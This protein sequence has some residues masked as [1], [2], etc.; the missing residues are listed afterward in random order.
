M[1]SSDI[2]GCGAMPRIIHRFNRE[3][4]DV[5]RERTP[6][7]FDGNDLVWI[8]VYKRCEYVHLPQGS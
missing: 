7:Q 2:G 3:A 4:I 5:H 6:E 1:K 8:P